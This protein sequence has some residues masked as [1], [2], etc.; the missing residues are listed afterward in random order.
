MPGAQAMALTYDTI[1]I[2]APEK[3]LAIPAV[4]EVMIWLGRTLA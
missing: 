4:P 2:L 1:S 3:A